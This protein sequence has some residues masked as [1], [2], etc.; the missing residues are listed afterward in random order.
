MVFQNA[1][2]Q[3]FRDT[4]ANNIKL[5]FPYPLFPSAEP[6]DASNDSDFG[7]PERRQRGADEGYDTGNDIAPGVWY[8]AAETLL[9]GHQ[10]KAGADVGHEVGRQDGEQ[11]GI[12]PAF[13]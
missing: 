6:V 1:K 11:H 2:I 3:L 9:V 4:N 10:D 7:H 13:L 5:L 8:D 12:A